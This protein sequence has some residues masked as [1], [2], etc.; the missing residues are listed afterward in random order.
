MRLQSILTFGGL[1]LELQ[2]CFTI[3]WLRLCFALVLALA[4]DATS[5]LVTPFSFDDETDEDN[6]QDGQYVAS[7]PP[8][9]NVC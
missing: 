1:F 5:P 6:S 2:H 8:N 4:L 7:S 9:E 3:Y